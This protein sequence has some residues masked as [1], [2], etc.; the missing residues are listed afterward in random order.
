V[1]ARRRREPTA[2]SLRGRLLT[3]LLVPVLLVLLGD[4]LL[5]YA[6]ALQYS[7]SIHD[8]D[9][10]DSALTLAT[11]EGSTG[12]AGDISPQ[13]RF[14]LEF[15][16]DG[17]T[18]YTIESSKR[19]RVDQN[20][21]IPVA[22]I[23][24]AVGAAPVLYDTMHNRRPLRAAVMR[25]PSAFDASDILTIR[26]A[27]TLKGR[28]ERAEEI[29]L[30]TVPLQSLLI[31]AILCLV[32]FGVTHGLRVLDPLTER[33]SRREHDL[34][35]I[36]ERDVPVEILPLTRT[37]DGLF[38]RL[39]GVFALQERFIADAAHQ[40]RTPLA[41][42][43]MHVERAQADRR[44]ETL[45]DAFDHIERLTAR[46][47]RASTQ[48]LSLTRA[49]SPHS[50]DATQ[51]LIDLQQLVPTMVGQR[52]HDAIAAK[53]DLGYETTGLP[54]PIRGDALMLQELL[55]NLI[56]NAIAHA[57][58]GSTL[59]VGIGSDPAGGTTLVVE[60]NGPGVADEWLTRLGE[61]FFRAP[62][63]HEGGTGLGLA[64][65]ERIADVHH[66]TVRF[67]RGDGGGLRVEIVFPVPG[68]R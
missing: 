4:A 41:G 65:V 58:G 44:P 22:P 21:D 23:T 57:G 15:D 46:A 19:G 14:L 31:L 64:I 9:L 66:A 59:T 67:L 17:R 60:D 1:S 5:T 68:E 13:A 30:L 7:N 12:L 37:I 39:R 48:L 61:R 6:G 36:G 16:P 3:F 56:D 10:S 62:G 28:R 25:V 52:V 50:D 51:T 35:P 11:M 29:L 8:K 27:E 34:G 2:P 55:D 54:R 33:L 38:A 49:Q 18:F 42:L 45:A 43:R 20:E 26:V 32:W 63:A 40:L 47:A 24:P 53:I